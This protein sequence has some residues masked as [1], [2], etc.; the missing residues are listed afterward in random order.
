[1]FA[2]ASAS[3][4]ARL[5][6]VLRSTTCD[7]THGRA[8]C[9]VFMSL[10]RCYTKMGLNLFKMIFVRAT[11]SIILMYVQTAVFMRF[12]GGNSVGRYKAN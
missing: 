11:S 3:E 12:N 10:R 6:L 2:E 4:F 5:P 1:M 9:T 8:E 7:V